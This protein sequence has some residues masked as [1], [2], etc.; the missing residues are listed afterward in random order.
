MLKDPLYKLVFKLLLLIAGTIVACRFFQMYI[1]LAVAVIGLFYAL[2]GFAG[3]SLFVFAFLPF[4]TL[5][6][7]V[8]LPKFPHFAM[9]SRLTTLSIV[10]ALILGGTKR[11]GQ[12]KLPLGYVF[13]YL[14]IA[15]ISSFQ[16]YFPLISYFKIINFSAFILGIYV[17]TQNIDQRP[18]DIFFIRA[19][20]LAIACVLIWGSLATLPFPSIA[21][22]TS[23]R[24]VIS[25]EGLDAAEDVLA[26]AE[27]TGLFTGITVHSQFLGPALACLGGWIACDM[28]FVE[29]RI[30]LLHALLLAPTP[31]MIAMTRS[32]I[33]ILT[34]CMLIVFLMFFCLP[35][36]NIPS[37]H[38]HWIN[39]LLISF[40]F[41]FIAVAIVAEVKRGS[42]TRLARKTGD[43]SEDNR[44]LIQAITGSRQG[45]IADCLHDFH[46]NPLWGMG[47]QVT[48]DHR[49][50]Y[51]Q[52][53]ISLFS[54]SIEKGLLPLM[55]LGE[56]GIIGSVAFLVFLFMFFHDASQ[57]CYT[58]TITLFLTLLV[59]NMA[60]ATFFS[61]GGGG[62]FLWMVTVCGGF[63]ID[64]SLKT[65]KQNPSAAIGVAPLNPYRRT[66][67]TLQTATKT[68][69]HQRH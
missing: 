36:I 10:G 8:I 16:G 17:G 45:I 66:R 3:I 11:K 64:M 6:N 34:F 1:F 13:I 69:F 46:Q 52:G 49:R 65:A 7:P 29:R 60:E 42:I 21:Y 56:T 53:T 15:L 41:V 48:E 39:S 62:G 38:R 27:G 22:F 30:R 68:R 26:S 20:F 14:V 5:V 61:P 55:V 24:S 67:I 43:V 9:V 63:L 18:E 2:R 51:Q 4:F 57:K 28:L 50:R 31:I 25:S 54:A 32:R 40:V 37:K 47:F 59:T 33:G 12:E 23:V 58:A 19:G 35:R 44:T